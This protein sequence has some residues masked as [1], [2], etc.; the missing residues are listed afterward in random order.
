L[1]TSDIGYFIELNQVGLGTGPLY[2]H[3]DPI[4]RAKSDVD[5]KVFMPATIGWVIS[6]LQFEIV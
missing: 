6:L 2:A 5:S 3:S 1:N 4:S